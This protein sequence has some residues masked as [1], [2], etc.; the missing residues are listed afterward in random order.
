MAGWVQAHRHLTD[1]QA[2]AVG[3]SLD[4]HPVAEASCEQRGAGLAAEVAGTAPP[5]VVAVGVGDHRAWHGAP[6][7][8]VEP[9]VQAIEAVGRL[10]QHTG[11]D[12]S[13]PWLDRRR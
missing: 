9:S 1:P 4:R 11:I 6:R 2:L 12:P 3:E 5:G 13:L 10:D 8:D 7:I